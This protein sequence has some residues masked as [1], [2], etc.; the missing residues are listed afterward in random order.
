[1]FLACS[2]LEI[3]H[4]LRNLTLTD[5]HAELNLISKLAVSLSGISKTENSV[6]SAI[7]RPSCDHLCNVFFFF[8]FFTPPKQSQAQYLCFNCFRTLS[9]RIAASQHRRSV[10][11]PPTTFLL[12]LVNVKRTQ[13]VRTYYTPNL[14]LAGLGCCRAKK[15]KRVPVAYTRTLQS[16]QHKR[17]ARRS[18]LGHARHS[19]SPT[20]GNDC[21]WHVLCLDLLESLYGG[22]HSALSAF[23]VAA[24]IFVSQTVR[25][26]LF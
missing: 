26:D 19:G 23:C 17:I 10:V 13:R 25:I 3:T 7:R 14:A 11:L 8:L 6:Q 18:T 24:A 12:K 16:I 4:F 1:M 2:A 20:S 9:S 22:S 5:Q 15:K 21:V